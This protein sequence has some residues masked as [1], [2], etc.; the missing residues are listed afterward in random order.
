MCLPW[1]QLAF[2]FTKQ[3]PR[4]EVLFRTVMCTPV[5]TQHCAP[6]LYPTRSTLC[7]D[8]HSTC[9]VMWCGCCG[10][11]SLKPSCGNCSRKPRSWLPVLSS[12]V[13]CPAPNSCA[14]SPTA[15]PARLLLLSSL[16]Y[17]VPLLIDSKGR[18]GKSG[19][20]LCHTHMPSLFALPHTLARL[21]VTLW[22]LADFAMAIL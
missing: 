20:V 19:V 2:T 15:R 14:P 6:S 18:Q 3:Q 17:F 9:C 1:S 8:L 11:A 5:Q 12:L 10:Q 4:E 21:P 7:G 16:L 13:R 22:R